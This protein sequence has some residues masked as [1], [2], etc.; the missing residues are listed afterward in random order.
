MSTRRPRFSVLAIFTALIAM[1]TLGAAPPAP[2][3][4]G[5]AR[6]GRVGW[7]RLITG[8]SSWSVHES[9][10]SML[11]SFIR[12]QTSLNMDP[13]CYPVDPGK[14]E[15]LCAYPLIF[16]NNLTNVKDPQHLANLREYLHRGGFIYVDRCVNL[17]YSLEQEPFY[18][19]H[20]ALFAKFL[21]GSV[22]RE[23]PPTHELYRCYFTI[24]PADRHTTARFHSGVYGVYENGR[25]VA[26][27]SNANLQCGWPNSHDHGATSMKTIANIYV[28]AMTRAEEPIVAGQR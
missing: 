8:S 19:R 3:G 23:V 13:T 18:E 15:Q 22:V 5:D 14:L 21:P 2:R 17:S 1:K 4:L 20:V 9:N 11:A 24:V 6:G 27:V 28:Y 16:T 7:A 12:E 26:L 25:M 10:D